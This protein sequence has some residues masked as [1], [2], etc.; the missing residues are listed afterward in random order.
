MRQITAGLFQS[1][2]G[3]VQAPGGPDEDRSDGFSLGGWIV[4]H[5]GETVGGF[6]DTIFD[7]EFDLLLGRRTY[8]IFAA[9]WPRITGDAFADK[10]NRAAKYVLTSSREPLAWANSHALPDIDAVAALKRTDG[11]KLI[12][13]GS[14]TLYPALLSAGLVDRLYLITFP[15][16]LGSGKRALPGAAPGAW[17]LLEHRVSEGG[18]IIAVYAPAG[19][20]A[21]GS[22]A[23]GD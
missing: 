14:A 12:V 22:F 7:G 21:T 10:F 23:L 11:P 4:P 8:D 1:M 19:A 18:A 5:V 16:I 15:L 2:D 13:Q 17:R 6:I 3:I 20:V 9:H